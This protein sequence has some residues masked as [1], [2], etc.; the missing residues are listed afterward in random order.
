LKRSNYITMGALLIAVLALVWMTSNKDKGV[1]INL[2]TWGGD[3]I[4]G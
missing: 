2:M 1:E 4:P 3:F